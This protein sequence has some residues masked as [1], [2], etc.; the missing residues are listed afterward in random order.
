MR[1]R[2]A[3]VLIASTA[4]ALMAGIATAAGA[5]TSTS[6]A[7]AATPAARAATARAEAAAAARILAKKKQT[8]GLE[9]P[10]VVSQTPVSYTPDV[11]TG[12]CGS[13]CNPPTVY[14][15]AIVNGDVVVAG[16]FTEAC[17]N[18]GNGYE[19]CPTEYPAG[20]I[21]AYNIQT[22]AIDPNF[23]PDL[24]T[25]PVYS[26]VADPGNNSVF[27]GGSFTTVN[28][29]AQAGVA[30]L[31]VTPGDQ[32]TDGQLVSGFDA[33][34]T[35]GRVRNLAFDPNT[36]SLYLGGEFTT[37]NGDKEPYLA[38]L[39]GTTGTSDPDFSFTLGDPIKNTGLEIQAMSLN[40]AG[41]QLA[42][43]GDFN[44]ING[45]SVSRVALIDTTGGYG[46]EA[47]LD[48]WSSPVL[49]ND[50]AKEHDDINA[51]DYSPDGTFFV[52]GTTGYNTAGGLSVCDAVSRWES[53]ATGDDVQP[54]WINY[55]GGDTV[56]DVLVTGSVVY[57]SGHN[58]WLNNECGLNKVCEANAVLVDGLGAI[59]VNTGL[60]LPWW[61][62]QTTRGVGV[63][64]LTPYP[65]GL[66]PGSDGGLIIG[67]DTDI[68][69]GQTHSKLAMLP[70]TSTATPTPGG[71][72]PS[73]MFAL[74]RVD[75]EQGTT[76]G[77][78]AM[79]LT[80][81]ATST[82]ETVTC[83]NSQAQNWTIEPDGD[84]VNIETVGGQCL[85]TSAQ[86]TT[87]GTLVVVDTCDGATTQEWAQG[88]GNTVVNE[89]NTS[90][91]LDD[92]AGN[93]TS[94]TQLAI[95]PCNSSLSHMVWPL[96][97]A[98]ASPPPPVSGY[99]FSPVNQ[100]DTDTACVDDKNNG[101]KSGTL[102][103][104]QTCLGYTSEYLT[105]ESNGTIQINGL[106]LDSQGGSTASGTDVVVDTCDGSSTQVWTPNSSYN[107]EQG[108]PGDGKCLYS[109]DGVQAGTVMEITACA[110][111][112][113]EQFRMPTY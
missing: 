50:C 88:T 1:R 104:M 3:T 111:T 19:D 14:S 74:G 112:G 93:T 29:T 8:D 71:D 59:D 28:G 83:T 97:V 66:F 113:Y 2:M 95:N 11:Y 61:G 64:S 85:D 39:N 75:G 62:P 90:L 67:F 102:V 31:S 56:K 57:E 60:A 34:V 80:D 15:T 84:Y 44:T 40:P 43:G 35:G 52:V 7:R 17:S 48:D 69:G 105:L 86:G 32:S 79:C 101:T 41:T 9:L 54:V 70:L 20:F 68:I 110:V 73:G 81:S 45:T 82:G 55:N 58:R 77:V 72:I 87:A 37:V 106:C 91:C 33:Q 26:V 98:P 76:D 24:N 94:G 16:A 109:P 18:A 89:G 100:K 108:S 99:I 23:N 96:P 12:D 42:V 103:E 5:S 13:V 22:G 49:A 6:H 78:A 46:T 53:G 65:A 30:E 21:F 63:E 51:I 4:V 107:L 38:R 92:P 25:G 10:G 27:I 47:T 36:N